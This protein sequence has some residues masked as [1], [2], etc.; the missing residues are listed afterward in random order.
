M[1]GA[2]KKVQVPWWRGMGKSEQQEP[3]HKEGCRK[4]HER[5]ERH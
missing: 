2:R 1:A 3:F 4:R 5:H